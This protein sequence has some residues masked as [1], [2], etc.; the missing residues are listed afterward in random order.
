LRL[1]DQVHRLAQSVAVLAAGEEPAEA[2]NPKADLNDVSGETVSRVIRARAERVRYVDVD[3]FSDPVW[4]ILLFLLHAEIEERPVR[5][6]DALLVSGV[7]E[8]V[9][10]RWLDTMV[11][12]GL[13]ALSDHRAANGDEPVVLTRDTSANLRRYFRELVERG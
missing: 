5:A 11:E 1:S 12:Y 4:D 7:P 2:D 10:R 13:I 8:T 3:L 6:S 9:A